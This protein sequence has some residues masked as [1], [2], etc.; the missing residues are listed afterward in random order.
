METYFDRSGSAGR[1]MMCGTASVQV[2]VD[3][4]DDT[5]GPHGYRF[6]WRLAHLLGPVLVAAFANSPLAG[7]RPAGW[8]STRQR[9]WASLDPAR[10]LAPAPA[11]D[12]RTAWASYALDA[13][14]LCVRT[15]G[16]DW[17][18]PRC[19]RR[20]ARVVTPARRPQGRCRLRR[21]RQRPFQWRTSGKGSGP[22][23]GTGDSRPRVPSR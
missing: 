20:S 15:D 22:A 7:G 2:C 17:T 11:A 9:V 14:V 16:A 12:P 5:D 19:S 21:R 23:A 13:P 18:A 3:S 6:R 8:K 10:T 1:S 4:G